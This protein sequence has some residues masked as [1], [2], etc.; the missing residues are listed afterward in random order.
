MK[1]NCCQ[2]SAWTIRLL[3][4]ISSKGLGFCLTFQKLKRCHC[5]DN[6][7]FS[8]TPPSLSRALLWTGWLSRQVFF[9]FGFGFGLIWFPFWLIPKRDSTILSTNVKAGKPSEKWPLPLPLFLPPWIHINLLYLIEALHCFI[10]RNHPYTLIFLDST[11]LYQILILRKLT[12]SHHQGQFVQHRQ[13]QMLS[14]KNHR[15]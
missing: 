4:F 10:S 6:P 5:Q 12:L 14:E 15:V 2:E 3:S 11:F 7:F 9:W 8:K 1:S 13:K